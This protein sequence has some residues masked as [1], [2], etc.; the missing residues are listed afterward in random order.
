MVS[1][2][3][4]AGHLFHAFVAAAERH[5]HLKAFRPD[6]GRG[7]AYSYAD[8]LDMARRLGGALAGPSF[9]DQ[10]QIGLLSEN[11]AE[12][13]IAYLGILA[14]GKTVVPIDANLKETEIG[15]ILGHARLRTVLCSD[16]FAGRLLDSEFPLDVFSLAADSPHTWTRLLRSEPVGDV[17]GDNN[18]AVLIYTSGTTGRPKAVVL[19]HANLL[20]NLRSIET[21]LRFGPHDVFLSILPLHHTFEATCGFLAPVMSGASIVYARSFKSKEILADIGYNG[22]TIMCGVPLLFEK[23]YHSMY[24]AI[25]GA[26]AGTRTL[27]HALFR[28]SAA[29]RALG[30]D[31]GKPLFR[32]L[33]EKAGLSSIRLFVSGGAA[34]PPAIARFFNL[35]G[36]DLLPGYGLSE[37]APV[38][39][40]NRPGDIRFG[41][42][43]PP[44]DGIEVR[45][46]NPDRQGIGEIIARGDNNTPG[47]LDEPELTAGLIRDGWLYTG[48]LG[49][50]KRGHLWITGRRK[51]L[52]VSAAGKNIYPEELEELLLESPYVMETIVVGR[53]K[54]GRQGEDVFALI[55]PD[56]EQFSQE[57]DM[58]SAAPDHDRIAGVISGVVNQVNDRVSDYKR[59]SRHEVRFEELEKTSTKKVKRFMY[60]KATGND[61][62]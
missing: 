4:R 26:P 54:S 22:V 33:R 60:G 61:G 48:D 28:L 42:V 12:W 62:R 6:G 55:V 34:L 32:S 17:P 30:R 25:E 44:L 13:P 53:P 58:P 47:Y 50:L 35:I 9:A 57:F 19:T 36:F 15:Y 5:R 27:F 56:L 46:D 8:A 18:T 45:I 59:I 37:C 24:R 41:S 23:M 20:A 52:I 2:P 43:G 1:E 29:G 3:T 51:N 38:V 21:A 40:V 39:S 7:D 14:A 49:C 31:W 10:P 16:T 11:C